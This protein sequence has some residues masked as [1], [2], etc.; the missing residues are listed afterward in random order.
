MTP[1]ERAANYMKL[2]KGYKM[3]DISKCNDVLCPSKNNCYR[4]TAPAGT[5]QSYTNFNR[6]GDEVNCEYF[7]KNDKDNDTNTTD[8]Q[9]S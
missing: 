5:W 9:D 6:E 3:A 8:K 7:I 2:K 4:Y 1:K